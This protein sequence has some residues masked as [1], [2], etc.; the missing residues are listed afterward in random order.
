MYDN[1]GYQEKSSIECPWDLQQGSGNGCGKT[2][3]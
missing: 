2:Y 3:F 1:L